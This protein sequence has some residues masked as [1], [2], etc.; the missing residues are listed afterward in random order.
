MLVYLGR[1]IHGNTDNFRKFLKGNYKEPDFPTCNTTSDEIR[2][3]ID[4]MKS[5]AGCGTDEISVAPYI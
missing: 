5:K 1:I 4:K 2:K 3:V